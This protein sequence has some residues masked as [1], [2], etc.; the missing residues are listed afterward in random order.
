M[1]IEVNCIWCCDVACICNFCNF[2]SIIFYHYMIPLF[3]SSNSFCDGSTA[4]FGRA[5]LEVGGGPA[6]LGGLPI[7]TPGGGAR[8]EKPS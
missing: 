7:T 5:G 4:F 6:S 8:M 3:A 2:L 1:W